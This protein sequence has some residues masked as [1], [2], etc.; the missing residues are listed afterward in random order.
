MQAGTRSRTCLPV[1][2]SREQQSP[3]AEGSLGRASA[4]PSPFGGRPTEPRKGLPARATSQCEHS[5]DPDSHHPSLETSLMRTRRWTKRDRADRGKLAVLSCSSC[6]PLLGSLELFKV[7]NCT[8][9]RRREDL[10][11]LVVTG[12]F[13]SAVGFLTVG[14]SAL[15][16][17]VGIPRVGHQCFGRAVDSLSVPTKALPSAVG[18]PRAS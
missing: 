12:A 2:R 6:S 8:P 15:V 10:G 3:C 4:G 11:F 1:S 9:L 16:T 14:P 13:G 7:S 17:A 18:L 5:I